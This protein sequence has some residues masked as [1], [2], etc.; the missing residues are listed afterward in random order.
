MELVNILSEL[1]PPPP[2]HPSRYKR[3]EN[4]S[5]FFL[6]RID[7]LVLTIHANVVATAEP[8]EPY[9]ISDLCNGV[10]LVDRRGSLVD[11]ILY[12]DK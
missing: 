1:T 10:I 2:P 8:R 6:E 12:N 4:W 3:L 11:I 5:V 7:A 9:I